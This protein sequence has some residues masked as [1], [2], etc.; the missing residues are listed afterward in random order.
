MK[1]GY[2][3]VSTEDQRLDLQR[4][5]LIQ[6]G[7]ESDFIYEEYVSG[8]KT[9]RPQL[10]QCLKAL[11]PGDQLVVWRL[12]RLGRSLIEL[13]KL[14]QEFEYRGIELVSLTESIDTS[15]AGGRLIFN[16]FAAIA[17]FERDIISERTKAGLRAARARGARGGRKPK[18]GKKQLSMARKMLADP[19]VTHKDAADALR[20][21][22]ATLYRALQREEK[23]KAVKAYDKETKRILRERG[24]KAEE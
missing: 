23:E 9:K 7:V 15:T 1:I 20:V 3:R 10:E 6:A 11:R 13:V 19:T 22:R 21:S 2:A 14:T 8:V 12:D 5:A 24:V 4:D 16:V 18:L 17:Q